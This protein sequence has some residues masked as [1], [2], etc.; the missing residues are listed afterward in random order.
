[1]NLKLPELYLTL[2]EH[3]EDHHGEGIWW[4]GEA[5]FFLR[6]ERSGAAESEAAQGASSDS[7]AP[8]LEQLITR[9][10]PRMHPE[11]L[12]FACDA[13]G[14]L[15]CFQYTARA[16]GQ[17]PLV[18]HWMYE[19][20]LA[21][22]IASDFNAFLDWLGLTSAYMAE[23]RTDE[24]LDREH[25]ERRVLPLLREL[26]KQKDYSKV[27]ERLGLR[28]SDLHRAMISLDP[29]AAGSLTWQAQRLCQ[30][31]SEASGFEYALRAVEAFSDC[32]AA[33]LILSRHEVASDSMRNANSLIDVLRS[34]LAFSG[35]QDMP[36]F[37]GLV[38]MSFDRFMIRVIE[39]NEAMGLLQEQ[40]EAVF[41][42]GRDPRAARTWLHVV[43]GYLQQQQ[44][45]P[46]ITAAAN[47]LFVCQR[48]ELDDDLLLM[49]GDLYREAGH[50]SHAAL[51]EQDLERL[52]AQRRG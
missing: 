32:T 29:N 1:M 33:H 39:S 4:L 38:S 14:N 20:Y 6:S 34:P 44:L 45:Y 23:K 17:P 40:P 46:A 16:P 18:V 37:G 52:A 36:H 50:P 7:A 11:L 10:W 13:S 49:L 42:S 15:Y 47:A 28:Q 22:P 3:A 8:P 51:V 26:G 21:L 24:R 25:Y 31:G 9:R 27:L 41:I 30:L 35:D 5:G 19:T 43:D 48:R 2:L 12:P